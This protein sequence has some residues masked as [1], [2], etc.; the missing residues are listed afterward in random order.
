[1]VDR[2]QIGIVS[3]WLVPPLVVAVAALLL[4][5]AEPTGNSRFAGWWW[6]FALGVFLTAVASVRLR[7]RPD[8]QIGALALVLTSVG[9]A[10]MAR[11]E[12]AL[13]GRADAPPAVLERH[14]AAVGLGVVCMVGVAGW[15][16]LSLLR[17]YRYTWLLASLVLLVLTL[18]VGEEIRGARL[19]LR[20]G[21]LQIQ[22]SEGLRLTL[23]VWL[24]AYLAE[25]RDLVASNLRLGAVRLPPVPYLAPI[26]GLA[27]ASLGVLVLQDDLGTPLLL[28]AVTVAMAYAAT[29][30]GRYLAAGLL[31]LGIVAMGA[32]GTFG[33]V[34]VRAQN[35]VD[36]WGDAL[37]GG[38]Q[39][40]QAEYALAA[41]AL[42][43]SGFG[44]G[45]PDAIP[46]VHTDFVLAALAEEW[47]LFG[48]AGVVVL[49]LLVAWRGW[50]I[51]V[52]ADDA[53]GRLLAFGLATGLALQTLLIAGGVSRL[54]PLT[55]LTL[56]FVSYGGSA[57]IVN[58][59]AVGLL[60][61]V[62]RRSDRRFP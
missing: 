4:R 29:G 39:Q 13:A 23:T 36:P 33:R 41:G 7:P 38:Y 37:G 59:I 43:G 31:F 24:A 54:L 47:G 49:L 27:A 56:P 19:W 18:V 2:K 55:G 42:L 5:F 57:M 21:P 9:L 52:T 48:V 40:V 3:L 62:S 44:R 50:V 32:A 35:W 28:F 1:M 26:A 17:R 15:L 12:P 30:Q 53:F 22:P 16:R 34:G 8:G 51:A 25:R 58:F 11:L 14:L 61:A 60:L 20:F 10:L 6:L 45:S 46:D